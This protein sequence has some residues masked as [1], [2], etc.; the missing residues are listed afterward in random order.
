MKKRI[1]LKASSKKFL[2]ELRG[3]AIK[4]Q[5]IREDSKESKRFEELDSE[6]IFNHLVRVLPGSMLSIHCGCEEFYEDTEDDEF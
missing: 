5:L 3:Y 2:N 1:S 4:V 6:I